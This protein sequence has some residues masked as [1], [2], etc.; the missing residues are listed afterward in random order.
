MGDIQRNNSLIVMTTE[1]QKKHTRMLIR[2]KE[3]QIE[4]LR[5]RIV[6]LKDVE[7]AK[8][9][10]QID[11]LTEEIKELKRDEAKIILGKE[12]K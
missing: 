1:M 7:I 8:V 9:D 12:V 4:A 5:L 6:Y 2:E 11:T 3:N 10:L